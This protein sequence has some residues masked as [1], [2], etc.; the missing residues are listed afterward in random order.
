M[1]YHPVIVVVGFNRPRSMER[2]LY[3]LSQAKNIEKARLIISIDNKEPDNYCV[4]EIADAY[5]WPFGEKQ[6]IY[7]EKRLGLKQHILKCGDLALEY[8]SVIILEDDLYVSPWFYDYAV[9]ALEYYDEDDNIGGI[10]L[11]NHTYEDILDQP[12]KPIHDDSDVYFIQFPSSLGQA[13]SKKH[14]TKF[15]EWLKDNQDIS[16]KPVHKNII[17][18]PETSWKK[19]YSAYLADTN[20][21][22]SFPRASLT[23]N[24]NDTG[25]HKVGNHDFLGQ[26]PL[27]VCGGKY[28]FK[29]LS[30]S[31]AVYDSYFEMF[32]EKIKKIAPS[33]AEYSFTM[34]LYGMKD[35]SKVKTPYVIT[36]RPVKDQLWGYQRAL[37]PHDM[38]VLFGL[39]GDDLHFCKKEDVLPFPKAYKKE[40]TDYF[41]FYAPRLIGK[42][43]IIYNYLRTKKPFSYL[44][45]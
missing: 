25:T 2:I 45:K 13:W 38:N 8:G 4:R 3:S 23:A 44:I 9:Q 43:A 26:A 10:S 17:E 11:Y 29:P 39:K 31:C 5:N 32:P 21:Y 18:W 19:Y 27:L 6:V 1:K 35:L 12:F 34:D 24:F 30:E 15:R 37:K 40:L 22:F 33:L 28:N 36:S 20:K 41:Y 42:K 14:W 7:Q 16:N